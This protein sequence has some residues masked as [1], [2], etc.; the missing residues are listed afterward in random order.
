MRTRSSPS[1]CAR[2]SAPS[3]T[4]AQTAELLC[5]KDHPFGTKR[6]CLDTGYYATFNRPNVRLVDL[7]SHPIETITATGIALDDEAMDFDAIVYA[8]GFDAMTGAIVS[9][10]ITGRDG[11]SLKQKWA[12]GPHHLPGP[13][14]RRAFP[15]SSP[16]PGPAARRCCRT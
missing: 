15:T 3:S 11:V 14:E 12:H 9:V 2:R 5:P 16:S 1:R 13:D 10:D 8:T 7:R 4:D 6:P